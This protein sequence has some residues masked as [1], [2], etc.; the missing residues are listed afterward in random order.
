MPTARNSKY[1]TVKDLEKAKRAERLTYLAVNE[2]WD[3][4]F[5]LLWPE[6]G[7]SNKTTPLHEI[8][9]CYDR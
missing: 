2:R 7:T 4:Y 8:L 6:Y 1:N 5:A 9:K 3:E